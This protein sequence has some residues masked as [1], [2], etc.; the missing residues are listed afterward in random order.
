MQPAESG[1]PRSVAGVGPESAEKRDHRGRRDD[2]SPSW[3]CSD[4]RAGDEERGRGGKREDGKEE[5]AGAKSSG[6]K[7]FES[8]IGAKVLLMRQ[9][10]LGGCLVLDDARMLLA[11]RDLACRSPA[12][13]VTERKW[14]P[15]HGGQRT[16][17]SPAT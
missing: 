11:G 16:G 3:T 10:A 12:A 2:I 7:G 14:V 13:G 17:H 8:R 9:A 1:A 6:R 15:Q 4:G 5:G